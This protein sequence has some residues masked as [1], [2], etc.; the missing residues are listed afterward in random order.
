MAAGCDAGR[1]PG[2]K[3]FHNFHGILGSGARFRGWTGAGKNTT[4]LMGGG[5]GSPVSAEKGLK[6]GRGR[7]GRK[8]GRINNGWTIHQLLYNWLPPVFYI[9]FFQQHDIKV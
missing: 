8:R 6:L 4:E 7:G 9:Q 2:S 1:G 5:S 3:E